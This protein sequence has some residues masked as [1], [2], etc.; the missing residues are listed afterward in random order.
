MP[1]RPALTLAYTSGPAS[2]PDYTAHDGRTVVWDP[3]ELTPPTSHIVHV[4]EACE[5]GGDPWVSVGTVHPLPGDTFLV[6]TSRSGPLPGPLR[7]RPAWPVRSLFAYRCQACNEIRIYD[8]GD[9]TNWQEVPYARPTL[10]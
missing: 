4:C 7:E 5:R 2:L 1:T 8:L 9:G 10:F 3:W 6:P